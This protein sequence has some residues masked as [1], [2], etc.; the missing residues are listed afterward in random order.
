MYRRISKTF[1]DW[2]TPDD[3]VVALVEQNG[4]G[5]FHGVDVYETEA[6]W[7]SVQNLGEPNGW[8]YVADDEGVS[9]LKDRHFTID[10][11][12]TNGYPKKREED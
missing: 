12:Y 8:T 10:V 5:Y 9:A 3:V 6:E 1:G 7:Q 4:G 11:F 2:A